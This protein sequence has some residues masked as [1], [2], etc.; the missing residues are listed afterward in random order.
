VGKIINVLRS[1]F[2]G[3]CGL[4]DN[5]DVQFDGVEREKD[6]LL[7]LNAVV[8]LNQLRHELF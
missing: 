8:F 2:H 3:T 6:K 4:R 7:L 1:I 5:F